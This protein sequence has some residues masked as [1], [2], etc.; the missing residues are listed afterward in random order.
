MY[1]LGFSGSLERWSVFLLAG[2]MAL[3][4]GCGQQEARVT[5]SE[6]PESPFKLATYSLQEEVHVGMVFGDDKIVSLLEA[7]QS[8]ERR[9]SVS[10][11]VLPDNMLGLLSLEDA[12]F[13]RLYQIANYVRQHW[14]TDNPP[15]SVSDLSAVTLEAPILVN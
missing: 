3:L 1:R 11:M 5:V 12:L 13:P 15:E 7:N 8:L 9:S 6:L 4:A 10:R 14:L 2:W